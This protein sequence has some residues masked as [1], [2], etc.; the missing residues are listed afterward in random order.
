ML[1]PCNMQP[2]PHR[3][4]GNIRKHS[5]KLRQQIETCTKLLIKLFI[6]LYQV[7]RVGRTSHQTL[8]DR[9]EGKISPRSRRRGREVSYSWANTYHSSFFY[10]LFP[11][12]LLSSPF[13]SLPPSRN[14]DPGSH[15]RLFSPLP[16]T[17]R[18]LHFYRE[19]ISALSSL[20]D[21]RRLLYFF[22]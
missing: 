7:P 15:S 1:L 4:I 13:Y 17:V 12:H 22:F 3:P 19:K 21:S 14:S 10:F 6:L 11:S 2:V 16:T 9:W 20:V 8:R 18:A 5:S